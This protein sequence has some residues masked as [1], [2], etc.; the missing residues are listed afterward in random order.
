MRKLLLFFAMCCASV[1]AWAAITITPA[2]NI[3]VGATTYNGYGIYGAKA[4]EI[5]QLLNGTYAGTVHWNGATL[6]DLKSAVL[7]KVGSS[8]N[9]NVLNNDDLE[10]L[11]LLS[12]AR[13]LDIDGSQLATGANIA[14]IKAGSAIE[15]VTLPNQLTKEQVNAAGAA[16]KACNSNFGSCMSLDAEMEEREVTTYTY[17]DLCSSE[18]VDYTGEVS[19]SEGNYKGTISTLTRDVT[20]ISNNSTF[21]LIRKTTSSPF[22]INLSR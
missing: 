5:A 3:Y 8:S 16:L 22:P 10:A 14:R 7:I 4:G 1:G 9:P 13:F 21:S 17:T 19:G 11:E 6:N 12:G 2:N 18:E 15:A 20:L